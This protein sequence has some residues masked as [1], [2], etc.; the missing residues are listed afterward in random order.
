MLVV[1]VLIIF[2]YDFARVVSVLSIIIVLV[3]FAVL[4][5]LFV[6]VVLVVCA[7]LVVMAM[8]WLLEW[9][10]HAPSIK[11]RTSRRHLRLATDCSGLGVPEKAAEIA[12]SQKKLREYCFCL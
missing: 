7:V 1:L 12:A 8:R 4:V 9:A 5:V 10:S 6:L 11:G 2:L 3:V